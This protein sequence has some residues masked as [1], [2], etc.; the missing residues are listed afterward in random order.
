MFRC[1]R[2]LLKIKFCM[3]HIEKS[4]RLIFFF[5]SNDLLKIF[6]A[7]V[8]ITKIDPNLNI[9][10]LSPLFS[11]WNT[12]SLLFFHFFNYSMKRV[13]NWK[14]TYS[15]DRFRFSLLT[16]RFY[17]K[18]MECVIHSVLLSDIKL[19]IGSINWP[20]PALRSELKTK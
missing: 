2:I 12:E 8:F 11:C 1:V 10:L 13:L 3:Q 6:R 17:N 5:K 18:C 19:C 4:A 16:V 7:D 20:T 14:A 9:E 15:L